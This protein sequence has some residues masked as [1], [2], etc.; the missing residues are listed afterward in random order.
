M[1]PI[2]A[3]ALIMLRSV[4]GFQLRRLVGGR[5]GR[6]SPTPLRHA[7]ANVG[8]GPSGSV[9]TGWGTLGTAATL[10]VTG[11]PAVVRSPRSS[12]DRSALVLRVGCAARLGHETR[13][14]VEFAASTQLK[15]HVSDTGSSAE[16]A[17]VGGSIPPSPAKSMVGARFR[18][19]T[20]WAGSGNRSP[21][22]VL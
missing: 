13:D 2:L 14:F 18:F 8:A 9:P 6:G 3:V 16:N 7:E 20:A 5:L 10:S 12:S 22:D 17:E 1:V 4:L 11:S 21:V 19:E 15:G